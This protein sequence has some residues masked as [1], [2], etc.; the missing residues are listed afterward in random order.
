[1]L[2]FSC[3]SQEISEV[4][5]LLLFV[6]PTNAAVNKALLFGQVQYLMLTTMP[7]WKINIFLAAENIDVTV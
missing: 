1:M 7:N 3:D 6:C 2:V 4:Q 5:H